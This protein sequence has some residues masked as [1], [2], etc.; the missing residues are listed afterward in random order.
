MKIMDLA[1]AA[2][3]RLGPDAERHAKR[4]EI[5]KRLAGLE[6]VKGR[7]DALAAQDRGLAMRENKAVA[8]HQERCQAYQLELSAIEEQITAAILEERPVDEKLAARRGKILEFIASEN[9]KLSAEVDTLKK[10]RE[11]FTK[12]RTALD[13]QVQ[14]IPKVRSELG[15]RGV[16]DPQLL[17]DRH[18]VGQEIAWTERRLAAARR[19][20]QRA[21]E[22]LSAQQKH[23]EARRPVN[24][25]TGEVVS[26]RAPQPDDVE[27]RLERE[28]DEAAAEFAAAE[29]AHSDAIARKDRIRQAILGE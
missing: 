5:K 14:S 26:D 10:L 4:A 7:Y 6:A 3:S 15:S 19:E 24:P 27:Q 17:L 2:V 8:T 16:A 13:A 18:V 22:E 25:R 29:Q 21:Q 28:F 1:K 20:L 9:T 12:Q 23:R 11:Q